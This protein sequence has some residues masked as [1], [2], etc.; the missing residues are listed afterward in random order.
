VETRDIT[1]SYALIH[2]RG[3]VCICKIK[4]SAITVSNMDTIRISALNLLSD[5]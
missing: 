3:G 4:R 2:I 5:D 1:Q